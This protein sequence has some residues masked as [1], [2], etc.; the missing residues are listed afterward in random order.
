MSN[1]ADAVK[2]IQNLA[3]KTTWEIEPPIAH[4]SQLQG[5]PP[6]KTQPYVKY[7]KYHNSVKTAKWKVYGLVHMFFCHI[8]SKFCLKILISFE[9]NINIMN[10][11]EIA[12]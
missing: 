12:F 4:Y 6:K 10:V 11:V 2:N 7:A 3:T 9:S 5:V 8:L 1:T